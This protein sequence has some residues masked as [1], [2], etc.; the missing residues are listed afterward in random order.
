M[1]EARKS[2]RVLCRLWSGNADGV[3]M[4]GEAY[5]D[6]RGGCVGAHGLVLETKSLGRSVGLKIVTVKSPR[7]F[8]GFLR[9][10]FGIRKESYID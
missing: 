9:R 4:S 2:G 1:Y 6:Y 3:F 5:A 8:A 10:V 7:I